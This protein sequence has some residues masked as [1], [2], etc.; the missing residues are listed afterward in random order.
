MGLCIAKHKKKVRLSKFYLYC[1]DIK[2]GKHK[3]EGQVKQIL[4]ILR[5]HQIY[6]KLAGNFIKKGKGWSTANLLKH[7]APNH[8]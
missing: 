6:T 7:P 5:R 8:Q 4:S 3:K 1:G 2:Y